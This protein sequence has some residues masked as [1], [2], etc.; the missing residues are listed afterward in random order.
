MKK[1]MLSLV[2]GTFLIG[3]PCHSAFAQGT[4]AFP[5]V[6]KQSEKPLDEDR[7]VDGVWTWDAARKQAIAKWSNGAFAIINVVTDDGKTIV[8][9]RF[10]PS[11]SSVGQV[12][13]YVGI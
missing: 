9:C 7:V 10:D 1:T 5:A 13:D 6:W 4:P 12:A 11:G 2:L 8:M 3:C